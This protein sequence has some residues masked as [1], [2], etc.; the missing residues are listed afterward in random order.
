LDQTTLYAGSL[1]M[2]QNNNNVALTLE[3]HSGS[4]TLTFIDYNA[5]SYSVNPQFVQYLSTGT[6][7]A[8]NTLSNYQYILINDTDSSQTVTLPT[9]PVVTICYN[10]GVNTTSID[11]GG[12]GCSITLIYNTNDGYYYYLSGNGVTLN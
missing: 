11:F 12:R 4:P 3:T 5:I 2:F 6:E 7:F 1:E 9:S 10:G 8:T